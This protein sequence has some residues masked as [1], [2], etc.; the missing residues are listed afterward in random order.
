MIR[1]LILTG[2]ALAGWWLGSTA[3][4]WLVGLACA[5]CAAGLAALLLLPDPLGWLDG[6][7]EDEDDD[8]EDEGRAAA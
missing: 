5:G 3:P 7:K 6:D 1:A 4:T 8:E 2:A